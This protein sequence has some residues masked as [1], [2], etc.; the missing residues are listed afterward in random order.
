MQV[1]TRVRAC[2][3]VCV[4]VCVCVC[5]DCINLVQAYSSPLPSRPYTSAAYIHDWQTP[6]YQACSP[7]AAAHDDTPVTHACLMHAVLLCKLAS[8][9]DMSSSLPQMHSTSCIRNSLSCNPE[10]CCVAA[11]WCVAA[12]G[13]NLSGTQQ[14]YPKVAFISQV[15]PHRLA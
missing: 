1:H 9:A 6:L 15:R 13:S 8:Q 5:V 14:L 2:A 10:I 12:R 4:Y 11:K 7:N 3:Q